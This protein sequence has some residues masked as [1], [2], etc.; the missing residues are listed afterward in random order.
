MERIELNELKEKKNMK[1]GQVHREVERDEDLRE[2][3]RMMI[4][5]IHSKTDYI[6]QPF[7]FYRYLLITTL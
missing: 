6:S 7:P 3:M 4:L 1:K 2:K 5:T